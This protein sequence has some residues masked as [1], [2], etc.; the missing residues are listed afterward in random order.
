ME[1]I[2]WPQAVAKP[3]GNDSFYWNKR[4]MCLCKSPPL[5]LRTCYDGTLA[6]VLYDSED[7]IYWQVSDGAFMCSSP[8]D[9]EQQIDACAS[10]CRDGAAV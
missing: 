3:A 10:L 7:T 8:G 5:F 6:D 4:G 2:Y 1:R 9:H